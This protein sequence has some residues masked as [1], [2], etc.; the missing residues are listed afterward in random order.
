[1]GVVSTVALGMLVSSRGAGTGGLVIFSSGGDLGSTGRR[2]AAP[3]G[4]I[5]RSLGENGNSSWPKRTTTQSSEAA[6]S[7]NPTTCPNWPAI[8][9]AA[10]VNTTRGLRPADRLSRIAARSSVDSPRTAVRAA[11]IELLSV[12]VYDYLLPTASYQYRLTFRARH[13][14]RR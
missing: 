11:A 8:C 6:G 14:G 4:G 10:S 12:H 1:M 7:V 13:P 5:A 3:R 9:P 2:V